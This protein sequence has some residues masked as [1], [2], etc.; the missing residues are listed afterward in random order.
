MSKPRTFPVWCACECLVVSQG[1]SAMLVM[2]LLHHVA[3][4]YDAVMLPPLSVTCCASSLGSCGSHTSNAS[5]ATNNHTCVMQMR[6]FSQ[7]D[8]RHA[9]A[10]DWLEHLPDSAL[11]IFSATC[12]YVGRWKCLAPSPALASGWLSASSAGWSVTALQCC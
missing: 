12:M 5:H 7:L 1:Y 11:H 9:T 3:G 2:F 8:C 6:V 10:L 4:A